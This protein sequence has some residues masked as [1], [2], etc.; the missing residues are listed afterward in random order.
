MAY[1]KPGVEVTQKQVTVSPTLISPDLPAV[2]LGQAYRIV[3]ISERDTNFTHDYGVVLDASS[4]VIDLVSGVS[5]DTT[6]LG[7]VADSSELVYVDVVG[8]SASAIGQTLH[9]PPGH[10]SLGVSGSTLTID[11]TL[12]SGIASDPSIWESGIVRVGWR[13]L[14][15][16]L[17]NQL[18]SVESTTAIESIYGKR[19]PE[20]PLAFG[21]N[22]A[23][24]NANST[25]YA[26]SMSGITTDYHTDALASIA[27][28]ELYAIAPM[29]MLDSSIATSYGDHCTDRSSATEKM[30]RIAFVNITRSL[31]GEQATEASAISAANL[32]LGNDR[33]FSV[34]PP[35]AYVS[36]RRHVS[37][38]YPSYLDAMNGSLGL[39]AILEENVRL[40]DGTTYYKGQQ[41][42][43]ALWS[44]I[45]AVKTYVNALV[46][47]PGYF[48]CAAVAGQVSGNPPQQ[49]HT[50]LPIG[51]G[52]SRV[53]YSNDYFSQSQ[54]NTIAAGGSYIISQSVPSAAPACRHQLSTDMSSIETRE[55]S[56]TKILDYVS[57]YIR[58]GLTP[59]IGTYNI[60]D[61]FLNLMSMTL[62]GMKN[63]LVREGVIT[64]LV[65][66]D[67]SQDESQRDTINVVLNVGVPYPVNYIKITLTF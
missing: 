34:H 40:S 31:A 49:G 22:I 44:G 46:P 15:G 19:V 57:K 26:V 7:D 18:L 30:E 63:A 58:N 23:T 47:V 6:G 5:F 12:L 41:I 48:W 25:T 50:N 54:L 67:I 55:L 21:L 9:I 2:V 59:Y 45:Q 14:D 39:Y 43:T 32:S 51:G 33:L 20:N 60:T 10:T 8:T 1:N 52:I 62:S 38:L 64:D 29:V 65:I 53:K 4:T 28:Q 24:S 66:S 11:T 37:T 42:T 35:A 27:G 3:E 13:A 56:I 16:S 17:A 36:A 61:S